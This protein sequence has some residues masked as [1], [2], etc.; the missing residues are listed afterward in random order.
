[1]KSADKLDHDLSLPLQAEPGK[2]KESEVTIERVREERRGERRLAVIA[3]LSRQARPDRLVFYVPGVE[4]IGRRV[5]RPNGPVVLVLGV[6]KLYGVWGMG[7]VHVPHSAARQRQEKALASLRP[8]TAV[9]GHGPKPLVVHQDPPS[10]CRIVA[11]PEGVDRM[12][13]SDGRPRREAAIVALVVL[14]GLHHEELRGPAVVRVLHP[15]DGGEEA[16][17]GLRGGPPERPDRSPLLLLR[18]RR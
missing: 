13:V 8:V 6:G 12:H 7:G 15:V 11:V 10:K 4:R 16:A 17:V 9:L 1:M 2:G 18:R 14:L 3:R 5:Y